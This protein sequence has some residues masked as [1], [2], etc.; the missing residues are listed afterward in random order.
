MSTGLRALRFIG[1]TL[2]TGFK[3]INSLQ[4]LFEETKD[5]LINHGEPVMV[6]DG[7]DSLIFN[8]RERF[9]RGL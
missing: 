9:R 1:P 3:T 7:L 2:M 6:I 5:L 4:G 8:L